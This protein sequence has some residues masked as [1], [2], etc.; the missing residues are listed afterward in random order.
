MMLKI[1]KRSPRLANLPER[2]RR[3]ETQ[4]RK[5]ELF[6]LERKREGDKNL[7]YARQSEKRFAPG[8]KARTGGPRRLTL[9]SALSD[10]LS[11]HPTSAARPLIP[12]IT[13]IARENAS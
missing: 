10:V 11:S 12:V 13:A 9:A 5:T 4:G 1:G 6:T 7:I 8:T 2:T 3:K